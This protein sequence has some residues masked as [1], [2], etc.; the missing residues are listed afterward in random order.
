MSSEIRPVIRFAS[1]KRSTNLPTSTTTI[2][3]EI[4]H[5]TD[6]IEPTVKTTFAEKLKNRITTG[7]FQPFQRNEK[8]TTQLGFFDSMFTSEETEELYLR[9]GAIILWIFAFIS[10]L[11]A[12]GFL[13]K[14]KKSEFRMILIHILFYEFF[15]LSYILF[16]MINVAMD[17]RL[18][19]MLCDFANYGK[20][21]N[22]FL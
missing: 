16:S 4:K 19:P 1:K 14:S 6:P 9:I 5:W 3:H 7:P 8:S 12:I 11:L 2:L 22:F 17:Y 10:L 18:N 21:E 20:I 13:I 15:Y